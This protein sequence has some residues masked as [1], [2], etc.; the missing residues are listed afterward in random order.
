MEREASACLQV[1]PPPH[2]RVQVHFPLVFQFTHHNCQSVL[3]GAQAQVQLP[4]SYQDTTAWI[5]LEEA[6][7]PWVLAAVYGIDEAFALVW[8]HGLDLEELNPRQCVLGNSDLIMILQKLGPVVVNIGN[9][10]DGDLGK[11]REEVDCKLYR[12]NGLVCL[13]LHHAI[14]A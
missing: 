11:M 14:C 13:V 1:C 7:T 5:Q 8:I 9:H 10:E 12:V 6:G 3:G 4:H 2:I